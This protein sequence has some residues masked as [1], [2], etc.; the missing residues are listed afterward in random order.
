VGLGLLAVALVVA[1]VAARHRADRAVTTWV[2]MAGVAVGAAV[3]GASVSPVA[4][5]FGA[6][7]GNFRFLWPIAVFTTG[8][9]LA[10]VVRALPSPA[11]RYAAIGLATAA[12]VLALTAIP[13]SYQSPRPELDAPLIP[14]ARSITS[15]LRD[16]D[17]GGPVVV[18]RSGL[19]FAEPY[20][21]VVVA[22]LQEAGVD[23]RF[24]TATDAARFGDERAVDGPVA[25]R[26][27]MEVGD[28]ALEPRP[29]SE[30]LAR[31][32][33]LTDDDRAELASLAAVA[34]PTPSQARRLARLR[35]LALRGTFA[36]WYTPE[37]T[38]ER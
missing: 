20:S 7:A 33:L 29:G 4:S 23:L 15:Q 18:D 27:S 2:A 11:G 6:V 9:L 19:F 24:D 13:T 14:V 16:V 3:A 26:V 32:S 10:A 36:A 5:D 25:G 28:E 8:A 1:Y 30:L 12:T 21:Y 38:S 35:D 22:A 31:A 37:L 17:L 34:D